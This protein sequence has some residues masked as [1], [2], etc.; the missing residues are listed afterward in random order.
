MGNPGANKRTRKM[1]DI[2]LQ[3]W[4]KV[5]V[6]DPHGKC[7]CVSRKE[8]FLA[9]VPEYAR[10]LCVPQMLPLLAFDRTSTYEANQ[11]NSLL[12]MQRN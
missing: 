1:S 3:F 2:G 8:D 11:R 6:W 7:Y 10:P 12:N 9:D 5:Y 4:A